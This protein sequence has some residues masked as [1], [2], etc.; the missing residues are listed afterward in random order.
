MCSPACAC[1]C[2]LQTFGFHATIA[3]DWWIPVTSQSPGNSSISL[4]R[5]RLGHSGKE[6]TSNWSPF[7][8]ITSTGGLMGPNTEGHV[9]MNLFVEDCSLDDVQSDICNGLYTDEGSWVRS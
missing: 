7:G 3:I 1:V 9:A 2:V 8:H 4:T 5:L 6:M